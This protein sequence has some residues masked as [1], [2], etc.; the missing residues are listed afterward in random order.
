MRIDE[1]RLISLVPPKLQK[2]EAALHRLR[3][4]MAHAE[5][6]QITCKEFNDEMVDA[7]MRAVVD[8]DDRLL[9]C[10][11]GREA[12]T[13]RALR[14]LGLLEPPWAAAASVRELAES[15]DTSRSQ[16]EFQLR[17]RVVRTAT[18]ATYTKQRSPPRSLALPDVGHVISA[19][20]TALLRTGTALVLDPNPPLLSPAAMREAHADLKAHVARGG[21]MLSHNP[22]NAGSHHGFL[23]LKPSAESSMRPA[24]QLLLR[25][26]AALPALVDAH[27]WRR[28]LAVP[29]LVQLGL[30]PGGSG[31]SYRPH[32]DRQPG[33]VNNRRELTFLVYVNTGWSAE[34]CGGCLRLHNA[35]GPHQDVA[36]LAGR[37]VVFE[38]GRQLHEVLPAQEDRLAITLWVE[39]EEEWRPEE[40]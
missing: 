28:R 30:Y 33:E 12:V 22:C 13:L 27:G 35:D 29:P 6:L 8:R 4:R 20:Q 11:S 26:L 16:R 14:R 9:R 37:V 32:L 1:A 10:C 7:C 36:P 23:D 38:S 34:R 21:V 39:Y 40:R 31:A 3:Q 17:A 15:L 5:A 24:T 18:D 25:K 2:Q 19:E